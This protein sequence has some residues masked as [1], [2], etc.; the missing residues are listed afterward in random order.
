VT[1]TETTPVATEPPPVKRRGGLLW[2]RDFRLLWAGE[3]ISK[4][5]GT[6]TAVAISL[7]AVDVLG[8]GGFEM[9]LLRAMSWVPWLLIGLPAGAWTDRMRR[10]PVMVTVDLVS[11]LL[12]LSVPIA[13]WLGALTMT[14]LLVVTLLAGVGQVFFSAAYQAYL[15]TIVDKDDLAEGNAKLAGSE[16]VAMV[17]GPGLGGLVVQALGAATGLLT[18]AIGF[19]VSAICLRSIR[20]E[21]PPVERKAVKTTLRKD[22]GEGLRYVVR[23][24][25]LRVLA[26]CSAVDNLTLSGAQAL[27]VIFLFREVGEGPGTVGLLIGA[28][29]LGGVLGALIATRIVKRFGTGRALLIA[30]LGATPFGLLIPLTQPGY[31]LAFFVAGL[32]IPS[33]GIVVMNV[34]VNGFRQSYCPPHLLGRI[35]TSSRFVAFGVIPI[36]ALLGGVLA[37][38]IG[39]REAMWALLIATT[40]GKLLRLLG[41]FRS[42]RVLPTEPPVVSKEEVQS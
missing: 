36:G 34:V 28:D 18:Q 31:G 15:P 14:Q 42:Q 13:A 10:R 2:H 26:L 24:P 30:A 4:V 11:M 29:A 16:Q 22:I 40:L 25:Y 12:F 7:V 20:A 27:L 5:G 33:I 41:P 32:M 37:D 3:T 21:E 6:V 8:A 23:D 39:I 9:G 38:A 17:A 35:F 1:T 19:L